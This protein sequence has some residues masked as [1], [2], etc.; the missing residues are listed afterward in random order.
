MEDV[1]AA[2]ASMHADIVVTDGE[3]V[4]ANPG[5]PMPRGG[6]VYARMGGAYPVALF[7]D[8]LID[9]LLGDKSVRIEIDESQRT[10]ASLKYLFTE[11]VPLRLRG[12]GHANS[13][14]YDVLTFSV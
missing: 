5:H 2:I 9:A 8:R 1:S 7:C 10:M 3:G 6:S 13:E 14:M 11:L 4:P 12:A